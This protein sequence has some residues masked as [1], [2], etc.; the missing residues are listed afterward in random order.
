MMITILKNKSAAKGRH[1]KLIAVIF[2]MILTGGFTPLYCE[3]A[4]PQKKTQVELNLGLA[5]NFGCYKETTFANI[6][7]F[8]L[9]PRFQLGTR[10]FSGDFLHVITADY[11]FDS[12]SSA[13]TDTAVVY[14]N[15]DPVTGE[16]YYE[17]FNSNL[18]FHK[19]QLKYD[20]VYKSLRTDKL[21]LYVGGNFSCDVFMQFEHYPSITGLFSIGPCAYGNYTIDERNSLSF[22][23]SIPVLGYGVRP[24]YAG[25][26]ALLMKYAEEDFL[27]ILTLGN[28]LS[29]HNYQSILLNVDYKVKASENFSIGL[30][31][32]FEYVRIAV[33]KEKPFYFVDVDLKVFAIASF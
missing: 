18:S 3:N 21:D 13:M 26:D 4:E 23:A 31:T 2:A 12:P 16:N 17:A 7:E 14:R 8:L 33:P 30:G 10:I 1:G 19:I 25:C 11:F 29:I 20:L 15:Y 9:C 28:F 27:K 5:W 6:S 32:D 22:N 24:S